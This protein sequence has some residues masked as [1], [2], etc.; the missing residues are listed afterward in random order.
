MHSEPKNRATLFWTITSVF[1]DE[2][3][4]LLVPMETVINSLQFT[5]LSV[6]DVVL[7]HIACRE[8]LKVL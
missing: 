1:L 2:Y 4:T 5:Y 7:G 8:R 3:F 6:D